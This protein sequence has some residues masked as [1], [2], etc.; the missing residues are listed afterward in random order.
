M[1][2]NIL[3]PVLFDEHHDT[4]ASFL[5]ARA[6]ADE[7]AKFTVVHVLETIPNY[8]TTE[9]PGEVIDQ[10]RQEVQKSLTQSARALPNSVPMLISGNP[11]RS[12][13]DYADENNIDCIILASHRPGFGDFFLGSTA[14]RVVRHAKCSVHVIR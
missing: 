4:Q 13:V 12:I 2:K 11:G 7:G 5:V 9:I 14:S 3:V 1:Y 10:A 8:V 6:L